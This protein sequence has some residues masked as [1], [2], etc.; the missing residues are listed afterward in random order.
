[1]TEATVSA[2]GADLS[3]VG[4]S[5]QG[6]PLSRREQEVVRLLLR[7][8][9]VPSIARQLWLTQSTIRNH[10]YSVFRKLGVRSQQELIMLLRD[11]PPPRQRG[12]T[13]AVTRC[14]E[15]AIER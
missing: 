10:L 7:G 12:P 8:D 14:V 6:R 3:P 5:S 15:R 1:M 13:P 11:I 2:S 4:R 9:R